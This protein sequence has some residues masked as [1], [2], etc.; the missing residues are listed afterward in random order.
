MAPFDDFALRIE[1]GLDLDRHRRAER[2][3][4]HL[5][6][7]RPLHA[8]RTAAGL[9]RQQHRVERDIV[10]GVM[11][12]AAGA[13]HM[14]DRDVLQRQFEHQRKIGAQEIDALAM[15][16]DMDAVAVVHCAMAQDGAI[17]PCAI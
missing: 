10:G 5:V 12:V 14:L 9:L 1:V 3:M 16:P 11:A 17:D 8:N 4:R 2:R 15:G 7:A 6:G 13:L